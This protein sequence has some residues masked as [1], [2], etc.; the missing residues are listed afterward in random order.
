MIDEENSGKDWNEGE[1][2]HEGI[3]A[4]TQLHRI[5]EMSS[6][7]LKMIN[8]N[9]EIPGWIQ[10]KFSRAYDSLNDVFAYLETVTHMESGGVV[11]AKK[12]KGLWANVHARR[13]AGKR[14]RRP[15][16]KGY[17]DAKAWKKLTE[18]ELRQFIRSV[19]NE[20]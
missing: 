17:P 5:E 7:M 14:A 18:V 2:D 6:M 13:K 20:K 4:V 9:D 15:G 19:L 8:E 11:E 10:Y 12:K 3:M 16:E 1:P